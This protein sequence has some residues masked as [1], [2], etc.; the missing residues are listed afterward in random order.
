MS[1]PFVILN[2]KIPQ[3]LTGSGIAILFIIIY[4]ESG[5]FSKTGGYFPFSM[6]VYSIKNWSDLAQVLMSEVDIYN[7]AI[8]LIMIIFFIIG[9]CAGKDRKTGKICSCFII[10]VLLFWTGVLIEDQVNHGGEEDFGKLSVHQEQ[11]LFSKFLTQ[12]MDKLAQAD[13]EIIFSAGSFKS[14]NKNM[15]DIIIF[16]SESTRA[17][18]IP[19]FFPRESL[20]AEQMAKMPAVQWL[21]EHGTIYRH[22]YTTTS[23]TTKALVGLLCGI[24]PFP[25]T[26]LVEVVPDGIPVDCSPKI[27][28]R[29]GY[30]SLFISSATK[31]F[32]KREQLVSNMGFDDI[33]PKEVIDDGFEPSGYFGVDEMAILE[34][35]TAWWSNRHQEKKRFAVLLTS[36][37]HHPYQEPGRPVPTNLAS[38]RIG[39]L[40]NL[41]ASDTLLGE[42]IDFLRASGDLDNTVIIFT[43]DHGEAF[44]EH[45]IYQHDGVPFEEGIRVPLVV[46]DG[47]KQEKS[48][49]DSLRQHIDIFPTLMDK[50][51]ITYSG[52]LPG[53]SLDSMDGHDY[54]IT[55]CWG[56]GNC[57]TL[58][59]NDGIK[60][61]TYPSREE[62]LFAFSISD[63]P[64]ETSV[65]TGKFSWAQK[66][67]IELIIERWV[68]NLTQ[69]YSERQNTSQEVSP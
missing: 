20:N 33:F 46:F 50:A 57:K 34:P 16:I 58:V 62:K 35:F 45:G 53:K 43:G 40:N 15:P 44:G 23:H 66:K 39:Y 68:S 19:G 13:N 3:I 64:S 38:S 65:I 30:Q 10:A 32:E 4:L 51:G 69:L 49:N 61:I 21:K 63:D 8:F 22:A 25:H 24:P 14:E 36:M 47:R 12:E 60:W 52:M 56:I 37:T 31:N 11:A 28:G 1:F 17:D 2:I 7:F 5:F 42:I 26:F 54:V 48:E 6:F 67:E 55:S 59:K 27:L 18:V 41:G 9:W 29:F